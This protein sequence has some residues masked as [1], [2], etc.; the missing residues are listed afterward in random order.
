LHRA[1]ATATIVTA[2]FH[3][4][5]AQIIQPL[6]DVVEDA[7][8]DTEEGIADS[9]IAVSSDDIRAMGLDTWSTTDREFVKGAME[10][11][12]RR[13]AVLEQNGMRICGVKIC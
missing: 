7:D 9:A 3:R 5:T 6:A 1:S 10:L 12:F 11:Y 4:L 8:D 2:Y 13:E